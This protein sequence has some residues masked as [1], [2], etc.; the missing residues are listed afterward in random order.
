ML[1]CLIALGKPTRHRLWL[2]TA[3][4]AVAL[5]D[6]PSTSRVCCLV[7]DFLI[8]I[9]NFATEYSEF[10][11]LEVSLDVR[12][13][14]YVIPRHRIGNYFYVI[15]PPYLS[16][17]GRA[18]GICRKAPLATMAFLRKDIIYKLFNSIVVWRHYL[19]ISFKFSFFA[20]LL[21]ISC[22]LYIIISH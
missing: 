9:R 5:H 11:N 21:M 17:L 4:S 20:H 3:L 10:A 15:N 6:L 13:L 16:T 14:K 2:P 19:Y 8:R 22:V 18:V 12:F 7:I 1:G